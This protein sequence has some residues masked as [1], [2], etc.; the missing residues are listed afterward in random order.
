LYTLLQCSEDS[1]YR[2][3]AYVSYFKVFHA[4]LAEDGKSSPLASRNFQSAA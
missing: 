1:E 3:K 2:C 4:L